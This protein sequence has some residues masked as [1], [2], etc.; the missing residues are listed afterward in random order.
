MGQTDFFLKIDGFDGE[1]QL[2]SFSFGVS[3]AGAGGSGAG[4]SNGQAMHLTKLVD[5][6][7]PNLF[8]ACATGKHIDDATVSIRKAGGAPVQYLLSNVVV[9]SYN[10]TGHDGGGVA[11][12]SITLNFSKIK[13]T[14]NL[15]AAGD[16]I[17]GVDIK[18]RSTSR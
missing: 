13:M 10:V 1:I 12:E 8:Q 15:Q 2:T 17:R 7:S 4:K 11:R 18:E 3:N 5:N 9:A 6:S 14:Y 16:A